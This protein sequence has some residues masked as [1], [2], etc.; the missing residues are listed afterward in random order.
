MQ[1]LKQFFH[2]SYISHQYLFKKSVVSS[3]S[4]VGIVLDDISLDETI[5]LISP[6]IYPKSVGN[7]QKGSTTPLGRL[8]TFH[9]GL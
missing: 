7:A 8:L 3:S 5:Q 6:F 4:C 9:V 2:V 1:P